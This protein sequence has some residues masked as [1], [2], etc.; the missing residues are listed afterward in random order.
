RSEDNAAIAYD[1]NA[2]SRDHREYL[3]AGGY[4]F[5]IGD[6]ALDY[7]LEHVAEAYYSA[8]L[9]PSFTLTLD[10][11]LVVNP[12]Y[13]RDRGPVVNVLSIRGHAEL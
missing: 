1:V 6:G 5:L 8:K 12:A 9:F 10:E 7:A 11:Q 2:L 3:A 13:N 4:G